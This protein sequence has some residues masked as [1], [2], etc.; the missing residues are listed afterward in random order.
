MMATV[1]KSATVGSTPSSLGPKRRD[2]HEPH[3]AVHCPFSMAN[4]APMIDNQ[5]EFARRVNQFAH[6]LRLMDGRTHDEAEASCC[7]I[8]D[9]WPPGGANHEANDANG[10]ADKNSGDGIQHPRFVQFDFRKKW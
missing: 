10:K 9:E 6:Y 8:F 7:L 2:S 5:L 1:C 3:S 4:G